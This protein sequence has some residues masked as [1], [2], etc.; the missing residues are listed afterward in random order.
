MKCTFGVIFAL[1]LGPG[2]FWA[3]FLKGYKKRKT[4]FYDKNHCSIPKDLL[5]FI[6]DTQ[7]KQYEKLETQY[8]PQTKE[9]LLKRISDE[10]EKRGLIDVLR[11]GVKDRGS[12]FR[13]VYFEPKSGLNP[14][15]RELYTQNRFTVVRQ[16]KFSQRNEKSIDMGLFV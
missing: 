16:L 11:R 5:G 12:N 13:L 1:C 15:H 8:G 2:C 10:I 6:M 4:E 14:E 7:P 9:K 3:V